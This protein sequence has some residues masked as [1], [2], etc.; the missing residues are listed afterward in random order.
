MY[1]TNVLPQSTLHFIKDWK[2][3]FNL[4]L[5]TIFLIFYKVPCDW[6]FFIKRN[7]LVESDMC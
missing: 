5:L 3:Y 4:S 1:N 2:F 6:L 7:P